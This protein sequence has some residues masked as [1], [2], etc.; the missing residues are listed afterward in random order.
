MLENP[1]VQGPTKESPWK[2]AG[3]ST[4][5]EALRD[6]VGVLSS[7]SHV[8][9]PAI[10]ALIGIASLRKVKSSDDMQSLLLELRE[11]NKALAGDDMRHAQ[12]VLYNQALVLQEIFT[13]CVCQM[14]TGDQNRTQI[15]GQLALKAQNQCR[16]TLAT[17]NAIRNPQ[18]TA[19]IKNTATNQQVN[20]GESVYSINELSGKS[21]HAA[22]DIRT[23]QPVS[24]NPPLET[25][26][27]IDR[28]DDNRRKNEVTI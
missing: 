14:M 16:N 5:S 22:I 11:L 27:E 24:S 15:Y 19:F 13:R 10:H 2:S 9:S 12:A 25:V 3:H 1:G 20:I 17:L 23:A 18:A 28:S 4:N 6:E 7:A 8:F 21:N 26:G